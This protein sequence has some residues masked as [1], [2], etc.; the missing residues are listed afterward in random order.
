VTDTGIFLTILVAFAALFI[1]THWRPIAVLV[2]L[3]AAFAVGRY[4][5]PGPDVVIAQSIR[6][7][8]RKVE[9]KVERRR[10]ASSTATSRSCPDGTRDRSLGRAQ[11]TPTR[12]R[13]RPTSTDRDSAADTKS[14]VTAYKPQWRVGALLG[15][16]V[17]RRAPEPAGHRSP[18]ALAYGAFAE[19]R[20][21]GRSSSA[22]GRSAR[23]RASASP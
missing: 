19:R 22:S 15:V 11:P 2:L 18:D 16:D 4:T 9:V 20:I 13:P 1:G 17:A 3:V 12:R 21:A 10:I 5:T 7:V 23:A 6:F 8:E 14:T